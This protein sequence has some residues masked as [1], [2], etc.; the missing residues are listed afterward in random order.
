MPPAIGL[1]LTSNEP[2]ADQTSTSSKFLDADIDRSNSATPNLAP[3]AASLLSMPCRDINQLKSTAVLLVEHAAFSA[4]ERSSKLLVARSKD[5][6]LEKSTAEMFHEVEET[7]KNFVDLLDNL[8]SSIASGS[9]SIGPISPTPPQIG[10]SP[11]L[12]TLQNETTKFITRFHEM[13]RQKL[14]NILDS[15]QWRSSEVPRLFQKMMDEFEKTGKLR[16]K[17]MDEFEKTGK[18]RDVISRAESVA[19][20]EPPS[21]PLQ[22]NGTKSFEPIQVVDY[23]IVDGEK[24]YVVSTSLLLLRMMAQYCDLLELFPQCVSELLLHIVELLKNF[25]SRTC[26]LILGAG[27]LQLVGLK[28]ISVKN[29]AL[30]SRCLQL[31]SRFIPVVRSDFEEFLPPERKNQLRYF[32]QTLR[33]YQDHINEINNKLVSVLDYHLVNGLSEWEINGQIPS[34]AFQQIVR[35]IG[36]FYNGFT[37]V[38]SPKITNEMIL[39][40]HESF[41]SHLK[42]VLQTRSITPYDPLTY[43]L[44]SQ[45]F[46]YYMENMKTLPYCQEFPNDTLSDVLNAD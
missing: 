14:G 7:V 33:D 16:D 37:N 25:N 29:L 13:K 34:P 23:L 1:S 24:Y 32:D 20:S 27:A 17:M 35:Q 11:L 15:E 22:T 42:Q 44:V 41:K 45:D 5:G 31:I 38:M 2:N 4:Q 3:S 19:G 18:L 28:T 36:K 9:L 12:S 46:A 39:R 6:F 43:G 10:R 40:I 26:Q 30:A 8:I 21:S